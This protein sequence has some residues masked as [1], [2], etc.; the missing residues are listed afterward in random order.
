MLNR[1]FGLCSGTQNYYNTL[2]F[3]MNLPRNADSPLVLFYFS[4]LNANCIVYR[5]FSPVELVRK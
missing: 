5:L 2:D 1:W 3:T 4:D